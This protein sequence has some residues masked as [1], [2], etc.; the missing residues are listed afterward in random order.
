MASLGKIKQNLELIDRDT[1]N[2]A[3]QISINN[4][5]GIDTSYK[6]L[7]KYTSNI[8]NEINKLI[9]K[10]NVSGSNN[11]LNNIFDYFSYTTAELVY[12]LVFLFLVIYLI[13]LLFIL[14]I[15]NWK[16]NILN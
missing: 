5:Q 1:N 9:N 2:L 14:V 13:L 4:N 15:I 12:L 16:K 11:N 10:V 7:I 8:I 6:V 3:N